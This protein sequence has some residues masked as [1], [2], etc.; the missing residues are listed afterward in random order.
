M[1]K[2]Q[3]LLDLN[4]ETMD[5]V[6]TEIFAQDLPFEADLV[7]QL[8]DLLKEANLELKIDNLTDL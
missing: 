7:A 1:A 2:I 4:P 3:D 5:Y 8:N 6:M